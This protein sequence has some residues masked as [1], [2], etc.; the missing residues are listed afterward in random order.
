M[1]QTRTA[2]KRTIILAFAFLFSLVLILVSLLGENSKADTV[3][4][5][6]L[7]DIKNN[8][9]N[10]AFR[11]LDGP[12]EIIKDKDIAFDDYAFLLEIALLSKFGIINEKDYQIDVKR[13]SFWLPYISEDTM[14]ISVCLKKKD[15]SIFQT[16]TGLEDQQSEDLFVLNRRQGLWKISKIRTDAPGISAIFDNLCKRF[17]E[18]QTYIQ[19]ENGFLLKSIEFHKKSTDS[20]D[21]RLFHHILQKALRRIKES[22]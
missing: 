16:I 6:F 1:S 4:L 8:D 19:T 11:E 2:Y 12:S 15:A 14:V 9:F 5:N 22:R 20:V 10:A 3:V 7:K 18:N 17:I 13:K 21:R